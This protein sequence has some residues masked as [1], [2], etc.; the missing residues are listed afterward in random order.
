MLLTLR[1]AILNV[2][3][4]KTRP[5]TFRLWSLIKGPRSVRLKLLSQNI[6]LRKLT[7]TLFEILFVSLCWE[8]TIH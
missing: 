8:F 1:T 2:P 5:L 4:T 7:Q 6:S 3:H